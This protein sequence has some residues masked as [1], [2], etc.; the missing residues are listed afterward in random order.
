MTAILLVLTFIIGAVVGS[1]LNVVIYRLP[2]IL[3]NQGQI[4]RPFNLWLPASH[5]P[6][7]QHALRWWQNI[8]LLSFMILLG[9][10]RFCRQPIGWSYP[11]VELVS[12]FLALVVFSLIG[13]RIEAVLITMFSWWLIALFFIDL[14]TKYLPDQLTLSLLW[15]GLL[16]NVPATFVPLSQAVIGAAS[17]YIVFWLIYWVFKYL[18]GKDGLGYGDFKLLAALGAWVGWLYLPILLVIAAGLT[19]LV[20]LVWWWFNRGQLRGRIVPF[21]PGLAVAGWLV[22]LVGVVKW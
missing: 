1:F 10:C 18:T 16:A 14:K 8:P 4:A 6:H 3:A 7:C 12:A 11:L 21:G 19:L 13:F 22:L 15:V 9:H 20:V 17:G 5:C 2:K